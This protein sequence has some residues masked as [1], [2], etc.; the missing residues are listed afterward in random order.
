MGFSDILGVKV[1][2]RAIGAAT[3][4]KPSD[5]DGDGDGF[6]TG[7]DGRDDIPAP[8]KIESLVQR[9]GSVLRFFRL[10]H[11]H[12]ADVE[13][14]N[15]LN[16]RGDVVK[17]MWAFKNSVEWKE[18]KPFKSAES[19]LN[20][21]ENLEKKFSKKHGDIRDPKNMSK[22]VR[23][24]FPNL[25]KNLDLTALYPS[26]NEDGSVRSIDV[27]RVVMLLEGAER[28][29]ETAKRIDVISVDGKMTGGLFGGN[30][31]G[32]FVY[33]ASDN[34]DKPFF[35]GLDFSPDKE[36]IFAKDHGWGLKIV[37]DM[38]DAGYSKEDIDYFYGAYLASHEFGHAKHILRAVEK[39]G[40][41]FDARSEKEL[42]A[43]LKAMAAERYWQRFD[44][45]EEL[46]VA[47]RGELLIR[48]DKA[49]YKDKSDAERRRLALM[50][51]MEEAEKFY[52]TRF[53]DRDA[54]WDDLSD[55]ER[56][57]ISQ[58]EEW[59][60]VSGYASVNGLE[61]VAET[62]SQGLMGY[63]EGHTPTHWAKMADWLKAKSAKV[64]DGLVRK[65]VKD[66]YPD[67]T[68]KVT[69]L[70][71]G[72]VGAKPDKKEA[73]MN[74][75]TKSFKIKLIG[76]SIGDVGQFF[77]EA[78]FDG[79]GDGFKR[80]R[81]GKDNVPV[82]A[83]AARHVGSKFVDLFKKHQ[84]DMEDKHGDLRNPDNARKAIKKSFPNLREFDLIDENKTTPLN[85][86]E[87]SRVVS[88]LKV[89][90]D[91]K[92]ADSIHKIGLFDGSLP[93][94]LK[95]ANAADVIGLAQHNG[96]FQ[97]EHS[98]MFNKDIT[99]TPQYVSR[100]NGPVDGGWGDY[101][102]HEMVKAG[103]PQ[104]EIDAFWG[105]Y[106]VNHEWGH[107]EHH[108][109]AFEHAGLSFNETA[110]DLLRRAI[111]EKGMDEKKFFIQLEARIKAEQAKN[112][113][114]VANDVREAMVYAVMMQ[115]RLDIMKVMN[116]GK[117]D[118]L[119]PGELRQLGGN[120]PRTVSPYAATNFMELVAEKRAGGRLGHV[121]GDA[122]NPAWRK[123]NAFIDGGQKAE[124]A[125]DTTGMSRQARR[126][127]ERAAAKK[128]KDAKEPDM[129]D[130]RFNN[131]LK[132][133]AN[134]LFT[135]FSRCEGF[136][137]LT[138]GA[139]QKSFSSVREIKIFE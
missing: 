81:D 96:V 137:H 18:R 130:V 2:G 83:S 121:S 25:Y 13:Q 104:S 9:N 20:N 139:K 111:K 86:F 65:S 35:A 21:L 122:N 60:K 61:F 42:V 44:T 98:L 29:P 72:F 48:G 89:A 133:D 77:D 87:H 43:N 82:V 105:M 6:L 115:H 19:I 90:E 57:D 49:R 15:V 70:C 54:L 108:V 94:E 71:D 68:G 126:A 58:R 33:G 36:P 116:G 85:D 16:D 12:E 110:E 138:A 24:A 39:D 66:I 3:P 101:V 120:Y 63:E 93:G 41:N 84:K 31:P 26:R 107:A 46:E 127:A 27:S 124:D 8:K 40:I 10:P 47:I 114:V 112:P 22:A 7:P 5:F 134:G 51:L 11:S 113:P 123:L 64:K 100:P 88:L 119:L 129:M 17:Q 14:I 99:R 76:P 92:V 103:A 136:T 91:K 75:K 45:D 97:I 59:Q 1:L 80:G 52:F 128:K 55:S 118:D 56:A 67:V 32:V 109:A 135:V 117:E 34:A 23:S 95:G 53:N 30:L 28:D 125:I 74:N 78:E 37:T 62:I 4:E 69:A 79:D 73:N 131:K 38:R 132:P 50:Y 106:L 102:A